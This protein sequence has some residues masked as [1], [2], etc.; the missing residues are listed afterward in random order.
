[1]NVGEMIYVPAGAD[2]TRTNAY[3]ARIVELYATDANEHGDQHVRL[4]IV[5]ADGSPSRRT[6]ATRTAFLHV[7]DIRPIDN[8]AIR[9]VRDDQAAGSVNPAAD[10]VWVAARDAAGQMTEAEADAYYSALESQK[11]AKLA[12][13][14]IST[15][16]LPCPECGA[17][18]GEECRWPDGGTCTAR[19]PVVDRRS[20]T[21]REIDRRTAEQL[22]A[23]R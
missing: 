4:E 1:M 5:R 2:L 10:P 13:S 22:R 16:Q 20:P 15:Q 8:I 18:P 11:P 3:Y 21:E 7:A 9:K 23:G 19:I 6:V 12:P 14:Q 17:E